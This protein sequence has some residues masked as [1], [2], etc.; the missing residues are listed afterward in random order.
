MMEED[1]LT[2][3]SI[4][5]QH[6]LTIDD[7]LIKSYQENITNIHHTLHENSGADHNFLGWLDLPETFDHQEFSRIQTK[8]EKIRNDSDIFVVIGIG[9]SY[10]GARAAIHLL[11]H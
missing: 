10:L 3:V 11:T 1:N 9:G 4:D 2:H 7:A 5:Y 6:A 8:A